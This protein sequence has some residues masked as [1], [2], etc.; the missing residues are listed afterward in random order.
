M[1]LTSLEP[2]LRSE[3]EYSRFVH[4]LVHAVDFAKDIPGGFVGLYLDAGSSANPYSTE[5]QPGDAHAVGDGTCHL[6]E[7]EQSA[8]M[9]PISR[10]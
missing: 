8:A 10:F 9:P 2:L 5:C 3:R 4:V 1:R 6:T 7:A